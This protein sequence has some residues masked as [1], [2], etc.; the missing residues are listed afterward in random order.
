MMEVINQ[1]GN[2]FRNYSTEEQAIIH[3]N[4]KLAII[5]RDI[6][7]TTILD[8]QGKLV[9]NIQSVITAEKRKISAIKEEINGRITPIGN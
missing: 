7:N 4:Y 6:L 1:K 3:N 5:M 8:E 2:D 9:P